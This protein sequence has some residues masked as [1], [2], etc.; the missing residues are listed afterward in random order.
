V[1]LW[2]EAEA[3]EKQA[4]E[5]ITTAAEKYKIGHYMWDVANMHAEL[6]K[7]KGKK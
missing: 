1:G 3:D 4:K 2:Y 6:F 7:A 5:H